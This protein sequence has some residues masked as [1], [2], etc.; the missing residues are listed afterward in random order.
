MHI[1][2]KKRWK[3]KSTHTTHTN[4]ETDT[5]TRTNTETHTHSRTN[6]ET[7]AHKSMQTLHKHPPHTHTHTSGE[8]HIANTIQGDI[9][10]NK[11]R[12]D[13]TNNF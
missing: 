13:D 8:T 9:R 2:T 11:L 12:N 7:H 1:D 5:H 6:T 3:K 10:E 4:A